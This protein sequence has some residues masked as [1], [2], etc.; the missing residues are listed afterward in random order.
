MFGLSEEFGLRPFEN[1]TFMVVSQNY[2]Y[3]SGAAIIRSI[4]F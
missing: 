2:G 4:V 3:H 1:R